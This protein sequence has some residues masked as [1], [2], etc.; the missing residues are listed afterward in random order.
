MSD[1]SSVARAGRWIDRN[2]REMIQAKRS[3]LIALAVFSFAVLLMQAYRPFTQ[4]EGGD[5]AIWDYIAQCILRGQLPYRD[6]VEI[7]GPGGAYISA[8]G[9]AIGRLFG[10][11]DVLA[12]RGVEVLLVGLL[13]AVIF[14]IAEAFLRNRT[15]ALLASAIPLMSDHFCEWMAG[16]TQSK[17]SMILFGMLSL[18]LIAKNRPF[19]AGFCSMLSCTC[20]QPGLLFTGVCVLFFSRCLT[21]WN[22]WK[23]AK[24]LLGA[25]VP[26]GL[27]AIYFYAR[28]GFGDLWRWTIVFNYSVYAPRTSRSLIEAIDH[29]WKVMLRIFGWDLIIVFASIAGAM[30][31]VLRQKRSR[32]DQTR[33]RSDDER[34]QRLAVITL[35]LPPII[36]LIFCLVNFQAGPDLI[37]FFPF[38][39]I[40]FGAFVAVLSERLKGGEWLA[41]AALVAVACTALGRG[42]LYRPY[43]G[44]SV[45]TQMANAGEMARLLKPGDRIYVHGAAEI[46]VL[47]DVP[48]ASPYLFFD[49]GKDEFIAASRG[50][51]FDSVIREIDGL[52]PKIVVLT[53][54]QKVQHRAEL[55]GWAGEN[56]ETIDL[57]GYKGAFLR[58]DHSS[59][60]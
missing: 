18:L 3:R 51:S 10:V 15:A 56:Y 48:N 58:K 7:K 32:S 14:L 19:W 34:A 49:W 9:I 46:L 41:R 16:G 40:F 24:V 1:E 42:A 25:A 22:D 38:I 33:A 17:L 39:A 43:S 4:S 45:Q 21:R 28:G 57:P 5:E 47:L 55:E 13:S 52:K 6:V 36:Y 59:G 54:L 31:F 8:A 44:P 30:V 29:L 11:K 50:L 2:W 23:A 26:L 37:P 12:I 53:R 20:W 60:R 27:L 35:L